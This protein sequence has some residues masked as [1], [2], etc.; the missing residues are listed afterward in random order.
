[1]KN[2]YT[3]IVLL[4]CISIAQAQTFE[5]S[6]SYVGINGSTNNHQIAF[7]ATPS[8]S[9]TNGITADMGGGF[10]VPSGL[11]IGNFVIGDSAIPASEW[12]SQSLGASNSNGDPYFVSRTEGGGSSIILN[13]SG[14]FQLVLFDVIAD[15][16]PSIGNITFVENGDPVFN[17]ILFVQNYIN[18][19]LGSGTIDAYSQNN[20]SAN[21]I[22]FSV[23]GIEGNLLLNNIKI[24]PN[25]TSDF[26]NISSNTKIEKIKLFNILG[27]QVLSISESSVIKVAHLQSGVYF[28]KIFSNAQHLTRKII[29]E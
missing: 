12:T 15:P 16:N 24:Y 20:P 14:P 21:S 23:L 1:M 9:I 2:L 5:F 22:D 17:E 7:I 29:I 4:L 3:T 18:I 27:K 6:L 25:P 26:I 13:G 11:T 28:L 8:S 10:Y 19:N